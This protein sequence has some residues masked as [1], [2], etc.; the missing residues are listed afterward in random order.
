MTPARLHAAAL[1]G[2]ADDTE[3]AFYEAMQNGD[4][5]AMMACWA[6]ED[7]IVCIHPGSTRLVGPAMIRAAYEALFSSGVIR[8][9]PRRV[10]K[11]ESLTSAM[12]SVIERVDLL[13]DIGTRV[14]HVMVTNVYHKTPQG[15][16]MVA[17]HASTDSVGHVDDPESAGGP[18]TLH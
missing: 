18:P 6:D 14:A 8:A 11:V 16:R 9:T 2:S 7:D 10:H 1:A 13:T 15:W 4:I 17:H 5:D 12:H 3:A